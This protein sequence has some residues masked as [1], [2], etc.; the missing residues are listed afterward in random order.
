MRHMIV[1][2]QRVTSDDNC[3]INADGND[4]IFHSSFFFFIFTPAFTMS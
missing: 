1:S 4:I 2:L 3:A